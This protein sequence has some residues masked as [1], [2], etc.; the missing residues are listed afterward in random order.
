MQTPYF[1]F[2]PKILEQN[3]K[4]FE[5]LAEKYLKDYV[6]AYSIKTNSFEP[7]IKELEKL[8]SNFEVA[9]I[10]E[11][12][13]VNKAGVY[14]SSCKSEEELKMAIEKKFLINI[15]NRSEINRISKILN[16]KKFNV[17][18][19][20][21]FTESKFGFEESELDKAIDY[22]KNKNLNVI[23]LHFHV[24]TQKNPSQFHDNLIGAERVV[25]RAL[26]KTKLK[27]VDLGGGFPDKLHMRNLKVNLEDYFKLIN[28]HFKKFKLNII[29]EPGRYLVA[30]AFDMITKVCILKRNFGRNYAILDVGINVLSKITLAKYRFSKLNEKGDSEKKEYFLA[31]PLL[32]SNDIVGKYIGNLKEEDL[33]KVENVGAYCYNLAWEISYKK[34]KILIEV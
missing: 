28:E 29:L 12:E 26:K 1:L 19:R 18:L 17:G 21:S 7:V 10:D 6:I 31:G 27:Y 16:G 33:I 14:N 5:K 4:E 34:P 11:I 23:C 8:G 2:K 30:D 3:Y 15:D 32:F 24:G 9:S 25:S 20:I 22:C 13:K